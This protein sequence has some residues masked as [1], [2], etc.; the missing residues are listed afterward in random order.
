M[1]WITKNLL[2]SRWRLKWVLYAVILASVIVC[3]SG[4]VE[5]AIGSEKRLFAVPLEL[6][7]S[8]EAQR[9]WLDVPGGRAAG[10]LGNPAIYGAVLGM[11]TLASLCCMVHA[12]RKR[13]QVAL[14]ATILVLSYGVFVSY[15]RSAWISV[16]VTLFVAQF[17]IKDLWRKTLPI[18]LVGLLLLILA[19]GNLADNS[20]VKSRVL[21]PSNVTLRFGLAQLAWDRFLERP[22][23]GWGF[24]ALNIFSLGRFG[25]TSHNTILTFLVDGGLVVLLSFSALAVYT[26]LRAVRVFGMTEKNSLERSVLVAMAGCILI[27]LMSGLVLELRYFGYFNALFWICAGVIDRLGA[28]HGSEGRTS[29]Y[30]LF[31]QSVSRGHER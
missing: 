26:L 17:F 19:W 13:T 25:T 30:N 31:G 4:L 27:F 20:L 21:N 28:G 12:E 6:G 3:F 7:G 15:T 16:V 24:G 8:T 11:G 22:L 2:V 18:F 23:F 9:R 14:V 10:V 5:Q 29:E 1:Y